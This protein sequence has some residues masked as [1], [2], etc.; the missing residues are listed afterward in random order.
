MESNIYPNE[1]NNIDLS[2]QTLSS[3]KSITFIKINNILGSTRLN[4]QRLGQVCQNI[5]SSR[6][7]DLKEEGLNFWDRNS[8]AMHSVAAHEICY[9]RYHAKWTWWEG[10]GAAISQPTWPRRPGPVMSPI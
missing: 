7:L 8:F 3:I 5:Q 6:Q 1:T 2:N 4:S 10:A 9:H